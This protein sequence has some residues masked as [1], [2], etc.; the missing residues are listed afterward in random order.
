MVS[1]L[2][3]HY[4][5]DGVPQELTPAEILDS[6]MEP[7][8][9][10]R[11]VECAC[12]QI[13]DETFDSGFGLLNIN[14]SKVEEYLAL[15]SDSRSEL[16]LAF[17]AEYTRLH[18]AAALID[19][20]WR[21][22]SFKLEDL[23]LTAKWMWNDA[24][25]C[26]MS[27]FYQSVS[28]AAEYLDSLNLKIRRYSFEE[29]PI[30]VRFATA[31]SGA[32]LLC[33]PR[34]QP[35]PQSWLIYVPFDT[36]DYRLGGSLLAQRVGLGGGVAPKVMD[37]DYFIDC[38]EVV[39]EF[40]EDGVAIAGVTVSE[41]GLINALSQMV[42]EGTG[43]SIDVSDV[44]KACDEKNVARILFAEVPG[45]I[46]Q[47]R[48]MDFDYIDA[49]FLLQDVAFYPLGHPTPGTDGIRVKSSAKSGIQ[50]I[51]ESLIQNAEGED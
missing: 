48:D 29:G 18:I 15:I 41:G 20:M 3:A 23:S 1:A 34:I 40:V 21:P 24:F 10:P 50:T 31:L 9:R 30:S 14:P 35:D 13:V 47:V 12:G 4:V 44:S 5:I 2:H 46:L 37:P 43:A 26:N 11:S 32:P 36:S 28:A 8:A 27:A 42:G 38:F 22:G 16:P 7:D 39:R 49:E 6:L 19:T 17:S 51:L 25:V 33:S 45:V